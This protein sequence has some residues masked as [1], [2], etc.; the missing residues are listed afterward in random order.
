MNLEVGTR[1]FALL[2][3][4]MLSQRVNNALHLLDVGAPVTL[5]STLVVVAE[6][7]LVYVGLNHIERFSQ[8]RA[9]HTALNVVDDSE[10]MLA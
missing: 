7:V 3:L 8:D 2:L 5:L 4:H 6:D 1:N 9:A 10:Q